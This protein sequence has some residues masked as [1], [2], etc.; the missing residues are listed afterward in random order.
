MERK[1]E[2]LEYKSQEEA[3]S[4]FF[5][6]LYIAE[7]FNEIYSLEACKKRFCLLHPFAFIF[8]PE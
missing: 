2:R 7:A 1:E 5:E 4:S 3:D 8:P 6:L